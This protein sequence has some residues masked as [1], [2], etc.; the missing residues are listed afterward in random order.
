MNENDLKA[1]INI[2]D[3]FTRNYSASQ[4]CN[5]LRVL[6]ERA[7]FVIDL[8]LLK[9]NLTQRQAEVKL[10]KVLQEDFSSGLQGFAMY[11]YEH[12]SLEV[13]FNENGMNL[14]DYANEYFFQS[15]E[16]RFVSAIALSDEQERSVSN[17]IRHT[18]PPK[19]RILFEL[20]T[21]IGAGFIIIDG[22]KVYNY[23]LRKNAAILIK[24][25]LMKNQNVSV[26]QK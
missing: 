6:V 7:N 20:N 9:N 13:L 21:A 26:G 23:S 3:Q 18:F 24:Q 10:K 1:T 4:I 16:V 5:E 19:T 12:N 15:H 2:L 11:L 8:D 25:Y 17:K 22:S 14:L